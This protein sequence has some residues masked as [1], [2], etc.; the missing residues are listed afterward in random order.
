MLFLIGVVCLLAVIN[1]VTVFSKPAAFVVVAHNNNDV[2]ND[3]QKVQTIAKYVYVSS[4]L[5]KMFEKQSVH[6]CEVVN[7]IFILTI[8]VY[9][10]LI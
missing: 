9:I 1:H 7:K 2:L 5:T 3:K 8:L 4:S 10:N 6:N